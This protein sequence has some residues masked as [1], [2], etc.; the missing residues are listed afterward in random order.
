MRIDY[1]RRDSP[2][3]EQ[4]FYAV[5]DEAIRHQGGPQFEPLQYLEG[6]QYPGDIA[7]V[8]EGATYKSLAYVAHRLGMNED[9]RQRWYRIAARVPLSQARV[10]II[11]ARLNER[12]DLFSDLDKLFMAESA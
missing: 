12:D 6:A 1:P 3:W 4:T 9:E 11:I 7:S 5:A 10:G 2:V 8:R